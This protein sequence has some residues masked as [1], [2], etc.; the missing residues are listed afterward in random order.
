MAR[1]LLFTFK[2]LP[3]FFNTPTR[4]NSFGFAENMKAGQL[5][6]YLLL[7]TLF[8]SS[9]SSSL[10]SQSNRFQNLNGRRIAKAP[11]GEKALLR[12]GGFLLAQA[13]PKAQD[14]TK[15]DP[16]EKAPA[17]QE[18]PPAEVPGTDAPASAAKTGTPEAPA[19][20]VVAS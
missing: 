18:K 5:K 19:A 20:A 9:G 3:F 11:E 17:A 7:T 14:N 1:T 12:R 4:N 13:E 6:F 10:Y 2:G 16:K 8:L 15:A